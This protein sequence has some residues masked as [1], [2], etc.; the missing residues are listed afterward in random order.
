MQPDPDI[1]KSLQKLVMD[2]DELFELEAKLSEFNIFRVLRAE[3]NELRHSNVLAW[4]LDP[5]ENHGFDDLFLRRW[6]M[7]ILQKAA[8]LE[9]APQGCCSPIL[10][11]TATVEHVEVFREY[12]RIDL[13]A[14]INL[15]HGRYWIL[16]VENKV[17]STQSDGQLE[18]Y[19]K[20]VERRF[21]DAERHIFVFLT[22]HGEDPKDIEYIPS[23]YDDV[24]LA[25]DQCL[26]QKKHQ[27]GA[28]PLLLIRHYQELLRDG[29]MADSEAIEL[30][31]KIYRTHHRALDFIF[32]N[33]VDP[34]FVATNVLE[35]VLE[36]CKQELGIKV[37][38]SSKGFV[39]FIPESWDRNS[40]RGGK[41]WGDDSRIILCEIQ[42]G[43]VA[44]LRIVMGFPEEEWADSLWARAKGKRFFNA[45]R[46]TRPK[47]YPKISFFPSS[48]QPRKFLEMTEDEIEEQLMTWIRK[49]IEDR[50]FKDAVKLVAEFLGERD[51]SGDAFLNPSSKNPAK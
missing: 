44:E 7:L 35:K 3:R 47:Q 38:P 30:A 48:I 31:R 16:C 18:K 24:S 26:K 17:D 2:C 1:E 40:N 49:V 15:G 10:A 43:N 34:V 22:A 23:S 27:T 5:E 45:K 33:K 25:I 29:F 11:A 19:R 20:I 32:E 12:S 13:L 46:K 42:F 41:A 37:E 50:Q 9:H 36:N 28:E 51:A 14:K 4:L 21:D 6:L 8:S 39:R